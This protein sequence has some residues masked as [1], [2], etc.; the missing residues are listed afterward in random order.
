VASKLCGKNPA[1]KKTMDLYLGA[2]KEE[3][4]QSEIKAGR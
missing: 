2:I 4:G 3:A 1:T